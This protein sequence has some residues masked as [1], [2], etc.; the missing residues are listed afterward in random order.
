[1]ESA[2]ML[3]G[4]TDEDGILLVLDDRREADSIASE[5]RMRGHDVVVVSYRERTVRM[6]S[7]E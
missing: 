4:R 1:M 7:T 2:I 5:L 6:F 3:K